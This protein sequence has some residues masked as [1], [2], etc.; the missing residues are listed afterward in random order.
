MSER[1]RQIPYDVTYMWNLKYDTNEPTYE[2][3]SRTQRTDWWFPR[4]RELEEGYEQEVGISRF[5]LLY[6]K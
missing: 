6:M 2:T 3:V 5:K 4:G 1:K